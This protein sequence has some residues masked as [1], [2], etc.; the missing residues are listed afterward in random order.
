MVFIYAF[1]MMAISP[2]Q[3]LFDHI[4]QLR[5][6]I[7]DG[8]F[9]KYYFRPLNMMFYYMSE[10][11]DIKGIVQLVGGDR[12]PCLCLRPDRGR[13]DTGQPRAVARSPARC[14]AGSDRPG[15]HRGMHGLLADRLL[16]GAQPLVASSE[17]SPPTR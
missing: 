4:W 3:I 13:L 12:P 8:S 9:V 17:R 5:F 16:A 7:Q 6:Q 11:F 2:M 14:L 1:Y 10:M 15:G